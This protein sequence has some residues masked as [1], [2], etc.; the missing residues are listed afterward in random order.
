VNVWDATNGNLLNST[1][2]MKGENHK[3]SINCVVPYTCRAQSNA[4]F[5][6]TTSYDKTIRIWKADTMVHVHKCTSRNV[7]IAM[8]IV[9]A[10]NG[11]DALICGNRDGSLVAYKLPELKFIGLLN[12]KNNNNNRSRQR[13]PNGRLTDLALVHN[14]IFK[15]DST[16]RISVVEFDLNCLN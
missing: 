16:G 13:G 6:I 14:F 8:K 7:V 15:A 1:R 5:V 10:P 4:A 12:S 11:K 2:V 9:Q 3:D